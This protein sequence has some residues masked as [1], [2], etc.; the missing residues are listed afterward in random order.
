MDS[1][2]AH[3]SRSEMTPYFFFLDFFACL[4]VA[5]LLVMLLLR[6]VAPGIPAPGDRDISF[7]EADGGGFGT[8]VSPWGVPACAKA[9]TDVNDNRA[10]VT[11]IFF[12]LISVSPVKGGKAIAGRR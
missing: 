8:M 10:A 4:P 5:V 7:D 1:P 11:R 6:V 2:L 12:V 9:L 3:V